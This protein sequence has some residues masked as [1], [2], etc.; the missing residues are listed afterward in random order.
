M[1]LTP[2]HRPRDDLGAGWDEASPPLPYGASLESGESRPAP[3]PATTRAVCPNLGAR[4]LAASYDGCCFRKLPVCRLGVQWP[5][6]KSPI[7][8]PRIRARTGNRAYG[9]TPLILLRG[10]R[11]CGAGAR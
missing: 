5:A 2:S 8:P 9:R 11:I 7:P 10:V 3:I 6:A 4:H 1:T